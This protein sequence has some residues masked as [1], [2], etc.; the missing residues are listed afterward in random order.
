MGRS[1]IGVLAFLFVV[2]FMLMWAYKAGKRDIARADAK[3][4]EERRA[5]I[6]SGA[7]YKPIKRIERRN[8]GQ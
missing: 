2:G 8:D 4:A 6:N 3:L 1:V 7:F 5:A